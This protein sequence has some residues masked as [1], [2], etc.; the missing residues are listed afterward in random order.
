MRAIM[1]K[2]DF[3]NFYDTYFNYPYEKLNFLEFDDLVRIQ[4]QIACSYGCRADDVECILLFK[5]VL[6]IVKHDDGYGGFLEDRY[7]LQFYGF[8]RIK[9]ADFYIPF[10]VCI[11]HRYVLPLIEMDFNLLINN[12]VFDL[13]HFPLKKEKTTEFYN[14]LI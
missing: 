11:E 13:I 12:S 4:R 1:D 10:N 8:Y 14:Q 3:K 6:P 9:Q 7:D 2:L 5:N